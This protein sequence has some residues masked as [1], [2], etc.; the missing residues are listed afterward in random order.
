MMEPERRDQAMT[1]REM[2]DLLGLKKT[3]RYWLVHKNCFKTTFINGKMAVD[4]ESFEKWYANQVK[5]RKVT[6]EEPG[7]ELRARTYSVR[8]IADLLEI[9]D[10]T[11]YEIIKKEKIETVTVDFCMRIPKEAF[12][13]WYESQG[14]FRLPDERKR[15][16]SKEKSSIPVPRMAELLGVTRGTAHRIL[17]EDPDREL[18]RFVTVAEQLRVTKKSF[19]QWYAVQNRYR[20]VTAGDPAAI[21]EEQNAALAVHRKNR[22][23]LTNHRSGNG[24]AEYL[25]REEAA[26]LGNVS[27]SA[28]TYW[29]N[30]GMIP[31]K[32]YGAVI[33]IPRKEFESF[34]LQRNT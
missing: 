11:F 8:E 14:R 26:I 21:A 32:K 27:V 7:K 9:D 34:L 33:R 19:E 6:G 13:K 16:E 31:L 2:G 28:V 24:S 4:D 15:D 17:K 22:Q 1:V 29:Y 18:F 30:S 10:S 23:E 5:Y 20:L 3:D 12:Q 25:T